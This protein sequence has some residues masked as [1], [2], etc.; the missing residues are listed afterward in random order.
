VFCLIGGS[1][2]VVWHAKTKVLYFSI[3]KEIEG[4]APPH[5]A[6]GLVYRSL[7][8]AQTDS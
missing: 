7:E 4:G 2:E 8:G 6:F 1:G 3:T 5:P